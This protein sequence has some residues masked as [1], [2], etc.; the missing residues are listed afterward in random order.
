MFSWFKD[1]LNIGCDLKSI[2]DL[3]TIEEFC[4]ILRGR[5][6]VGQA[7][8]IPAPD[9]SPSRS[10]G[11]TETVPQSTSTQVRLIFA[12]AYP[13]RTKGT[14][15]NL[16]VCAKRHS[17]AARARGRQGPHAALARPAAVELESFNLLIYPIP[18]GRGYIFVRTCL[19]HCAEGWF[20]IFAVSSQPLNVRT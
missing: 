8:V 4:L 12:G 20:K 18:V 17:A 5:G 13:I 15:R 1:R 2:H 3:Q 7:R 16:L 14:K 10:N 19:D 11:A 6:D 9:R